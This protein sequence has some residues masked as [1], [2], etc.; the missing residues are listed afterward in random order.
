MLTNTKNIV[1]CNVTKLIRVILSYISEFMGKVKDLG[2]I[3]KISLKDCKEVFF[4]EKLTLWRYDF[5]L[6]LHHWT[7]K[8]LYTINHKRIAMNYLY[9]SIFS[10]LS[11]AMLASFIRLELSY[12]GSHF[13]KGDSIR[14]IQ[15]ISAHGL[16]MIFYVVV[17]IIFGFFANYFIPYH[18]QSKDVA[19][20]RLNSIGF[21][22]LPAGFIMMSKPAFTRR[23]VHKV[24]DP[25]DAYKSVQKD[26]L[27]NF[28]DMIKED[29]Y[30]TID[31]T[32]YIDDDRLHQF[33]NSFQ[34]YIYGNI[35]DI[36]EY[37]FRQQFVNLK[38]S[39]LHSEAMFN[40]LKCRD[41]L[42]RYQHSNIIEESFDK[43][44]VEWFIAYGIFKSKIN[45]KE[46]I[47]NYN[48]LENLDAFMYRAARHINWTVYQGG[49]FG[50]D[51]SYW[52]ATKADNL[53]KF[54][55]FEYLRSSRYLLD[56]SMGR[57]LDDGT[58]DRP[59]SPAYQRYTII[60]PLMEAVVYNASLYKANLE[61]FVTRLRNHSISN[62]ALKDNIINSYKQAAMSYGE[63]MPI[64]PMQKQPMGRVSSEG[65][66]KLVFNKYW[67]DSLMLWEYNYMWYENAWQ[68]LFHAKKNKTILMRNE[69]CSNPSSVMAGWA[70]ITPFSS[71]TRFTGFGAQDV[72]IVS[73]LFA[74]LSTTIS[75]T[76]L[77]IT[78]RVLGSS[79]FKNRKNSIPF[80][81]ISLFLVMR[82]LSLITPVLGAAMAMLLMDRHWKTS[83]FDYAYGGDSIL[84][85]H[86]FWFF[87]HPEVYVV[88]IPAFGIVNSLL[89]YYTKRRIA[90]KNHLIWA[91]YVM[92]YMGF[93]VWGHHMYLVGLDHRA[94]SF[95]STIT[96]M[97]SLPAVVKIVNWTLT[98]L[99]GAFYV[100]I[101]I[102]FVFAFFTFFLSGGLTGLWLSHVALNL[103]V[104][105]TFYV[106]A[107]FHFMF[108][109]ATFSAI[110]AGFYFYYK[111]LFG[112]NYSRIFATAHFIFWFFGQWITF[113][114]LYWVGYNG[115]PRRYHDYPVM[116]MGWHGISSS[117]HMLTMFSIFIFLLGI[118]ESKL[119]KRGT[120]PQQFGLP[121][122]FKL[123][124]YGVLKYTKVSS[125][126]YQNKRYRVNKTYDNYIYS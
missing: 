123:V 81:T 36:G 84:F 121:R 108:S 18:I 70:F 64:W 51:Q 124:Q 103:Y 58:F 55:K 37:R 62:T 1:I 89:P 93:L 20:P 6:I 26:I 25:Y 106:V 11:G 35:N 80:I 97:I 38:K 42:N 77:L 71:Q 88:I 16:V 56:L 23:Q 113:M 21:W 63:D 44:R 117:G 72:A 119:R 61:A 83:F 12:P 24:W 13:F 7:K 60:D 109:C 32:F 107:H 126:R 29:S 92:A 67:T 125:S 90:S 116:Y 94:R 74:G 122:T 78:R 48:F 45:F 59:Y 34:P 110:F 28:K 96:V 43:R 73:V 111:E 30:S 105:D 82:M 17:P 49:K 69:K 85:H 114:P 98:F 75:F 9:F 47:S 33:Y 15:V 57:Y 4:V 40:I 65:S 39:L 68:A 53:V 76:N 3:F 91:T 66:N 8:Y 104:H 79:G 31:K 101:P 46:G 19:F 54:Y 86:L 2:K 112:V 87:G 5:F 118:L 50:I 115:L 27:K 99:N 10:G 102:Y 14:Y 95:Y 100:D 120:I 41:F 52:S 22:L